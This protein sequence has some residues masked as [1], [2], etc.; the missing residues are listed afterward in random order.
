MAQKVQVNG[1]LKLKGVRFAF[2]N[3]YT[4]TKY[5]ETDEAKYNVII[6]LPK[7]H[8]QIAEI[9][10]TIAAIEAELAAKVWKNGKKPKDFESPLR[11]GDEKEDYAGF[12][13]NVYLSA[14]S[15]SKPQVIDKAAKA[16]TEESGEFYSGCIGSVTVNLYPYSDGGG[17]AVGLNNILKTA[18]GERFAGKRDAAADF[19]DDIEEDDADGLLG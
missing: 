10:K 12:A 9:N 14:K 11:D 6:L 5:K 15:K 1:N 2:A 18:D 3:V 17:I 4:P 8:P 19:A 16:I 13:G 7:D